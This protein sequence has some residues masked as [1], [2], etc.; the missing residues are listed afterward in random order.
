MMLR[1]RRDGRDGAPG[2]GA[3]LVRVQGMHTQI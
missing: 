3:P 2:A 1:G